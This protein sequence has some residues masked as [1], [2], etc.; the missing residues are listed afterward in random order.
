[1]LIPKIAATGETDASVTTVSVQEGGN[2][3]KIVHEGSDTKNFTSKSFAVD[4]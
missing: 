4:G 1:M 2:A 3:T